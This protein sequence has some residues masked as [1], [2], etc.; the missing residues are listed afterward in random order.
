MFWVKFRYL[1]KYLPIWL[2]FSNTTRLH[3]YAKN[4]DDEIDNCENLVDLAKVKPF[5]GVP[6]TTK[7]CF[8]VIGLSHTGGLL[9]RG[10]RQE[11]ATLDADTVAQLRSAGGNQHSLFLKKL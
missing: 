11:K 4:A 1:L 8:Q 10:R 5:L 6:F 3:H 7:D 9:K 2:G